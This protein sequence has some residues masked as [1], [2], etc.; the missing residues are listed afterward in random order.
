MFLPQLR[1]AERF[2]F[3]PASRRFSRTVAGYFAKNW[4]DSLEIDVW[5]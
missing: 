4:K 1:V 3:R 5:A 2:S